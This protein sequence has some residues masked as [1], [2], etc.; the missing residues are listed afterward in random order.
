MLADHK[1]FRND[2]LDWYETNRRDLPWRRNPD[3]YHIWLSEIMLQQTRVDQVIPYFERFIAA[4]P[5]VYDLAD[6]PM[7]DVM[8]LWEGLGYYSRA[9]NM[10]AAAGIITRDYDGIIP[11]TRDEILSLPGIGPYTAA[12]ILSI[13]YNKPCAVVD[14]KVIRVLARYAGIDGDVRTSAVRNEINTLAGE[15]LDHA[16]PG[17]YN[18]SLM[19]LGAMVCTPRSPACSTCPLCT[20][21]VAYRTAKTGQ[22]PWK[23]P[24]KAVPHHQIAVG[25]IENDAGELLIALRPDNVMLGGLWEFPGGKNRAGES[26]EDTVCRELREELDV[27]VE[28]NRFFMKFDHA[29]SHFRI[30]LH[31]Y[32]CSIINGDPKPVGSRELAW[33]KRDQLKY[34]PFPKANRTI[35]LALMSETDG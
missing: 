21:C 35:T 1:E 24:K 15:L 20:G 19:E 2:L 28:V 23:S 29:Y 4:Y 11:K 14:G 33:V 7:H 18:Q 3:P 5:T 27:E 30:T 25:I 13:A 34:F 9:R 17:D 31:A 16:N 6:A 12:A 8:M 32:F 22:I 26:L 10:H